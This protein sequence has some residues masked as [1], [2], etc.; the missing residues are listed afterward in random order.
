MRTL[1]SIGEDL[2]VTN[3]LDPK[4]RRDSMD[5]PGVRT[6]TIYSAKGSE[7]PAVVLPALDQLPDPR[8]R[9]VAA[10]G[11]LLNVGLTCAMSRPVVTWSGSSASRGTSPGRSMTV[12]AAA[13]GRLA[14]LRLGDALAVAPRVGADAA[15]G[16][17]GEGIR[18]I[19]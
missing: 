14:P 7:F 10:D 19:V 16:A 12:T 15:C 3:V 4:A 17:T 2:L 18:R 13:L 6:L 11:N 1:T 9:D 8:S 5:R